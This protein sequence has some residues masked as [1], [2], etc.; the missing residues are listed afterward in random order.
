VTAPLIR[1]GQQ[2][3]L[4]LLGFADRAGLEG[5]VFGRDG[6]VIVSDLSLGGWRPAQLAADLALQIGVALPAGPVAPLPGSDGFDAAVVGAWV[7]AEAR[8]PAG[9]MLADR[10]LRA[11]LPALRQMGAT[12]LVL[13]PGA[14][15]PWRALDRWFLAFLAEA[16]AQGGPPVVLGRTGADLSMPE[17]VSGRPEALP[18]HAG[19]GSALLDDRPDPALAWIGALP[20]LVTPPLAR[21]CGLDP[22]SAGS[23]ILL[24]SG[25]GL[26]PPGLRRA[27]A[28]PAAR[29]ALAGRLPAGH[30]VAAALHARGVSATAA[31]AAAWEA[32]SAGAEDLALDRARAAEAGAADGPARGRAAM[33]TAS[34]RLQAGHHAAL[35]AADP[36]EGLDPETTR[37]LERFRA[38]GLAMTGRAE[39]ALA[40]FGPVPGEAPLDPR[41]WLDLYLRNI[42]ALALHKA[43]Q[44]E[45]ALA[46][47]A[48][49]AARLQAMHPPNWPMVYLN[50]LNTARL[51]RARGD[52]GAAG[53]WL[54]RAWAA[55]DGCALPSDIVHFAV[56]RARLAEAAG[57]HRPAALHWLAA[58]L[59]YAAMPLPE[60]LGPRVAAAIGGQGTRP[61]DT[62]RIATI[63]RLRVA[64]GEPAWDGPAPAFLPL[65]SLPPGPGRRALGA[66]GWG[67]VTAPDAAAPAHDGSAHRALRGALARRIGAG[68][69]GTVL[70]DLRFGRGLPASLT[71]LLDTALWAGAETLFWA[72]RAKAVGTLCA[73]HAQW[74]APAPGLDRIAD[75][76]ARFRRYRPPMPLDEAALALIDRL[77]CAVE[78]LEP[79]DQARAVGLVAAGVLALDSRPLAEVQQALR[80]A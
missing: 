37:I 56:L 16:S 2:T 32:L 9:P 36:P 50:A 48:G 72:G 24:P 41:P 74:L 29:A 43:G 19:P 42:H 22:A 49:I 40:L 39:E 47:E 7:D 10:H 79:A 46:V 26:I 53:T 63:L 54:D 28:T 33:A 58:A 17:G 34:I 14:G 3:A 75:G 25:I 77:P 11:L 4:P 67:V 78:A 23:L 51:C 70:I 76:T 8:G 69:D 5:W 31:P 12:V 71:E 27:G 44:S 13:L 55:L 60:A 61:E 6:P 21:D 62:G 35:A 57:E 64:P 52:L 65:R 66:P 59:A 68:T 20:T 18:G 45:T 73:T 38:W 80:H 30:W 15:A 1:T